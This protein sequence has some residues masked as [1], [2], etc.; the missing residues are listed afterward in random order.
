MQNSFLAPILIGTTSFGA[1]SLAGLL[2]FSSSGG[3]SATVGQD[4]F[5]IFLGP[6]Q[7]SGAALTTFY[8]G[9]DDQITGRD[10]DYDDLIIRATVVARNA[11][12]EPATW[13]LLLAVLTLCALG[14]VMIYST[15]SDPT[16]GVSRLHI[17]Q[18]YAIV[19]GLLAMVVTLSPWCIT[20]R[21]RQALMRRPFSRT[22]QAPHW[23]WSQPFLVPVRCRC[24]RSASSSVV[25]LSSVR[26]CVVPFTLS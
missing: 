22:V 8:F 5:G 6:D 26:R 12:P 7:Q 11:V 1:G 13:A 17:T 25:R 20:A 9:Y 15:T 18:I 16:R 23:P 24:S 2:N 21:V 4:G 19:I 14:V 10:D 3:G